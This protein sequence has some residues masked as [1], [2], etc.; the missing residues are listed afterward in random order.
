MTVLQTPKKEDVTVLA[1]FYDL[2]YAREGTP[3]TEKRI[4][5]R[6]HLL[7]VQRGV[8]L[9]LINA[10]DVT[11]QELVKKA[12]GKGKF[13]DT[14]IALRALSQYLR[15]FNWNSLEKTQEE[16]ALLSVRKIAQLLVSYKSNFDLWNQVSPD[17]YDFQRTL[18]VETNTN[19]A[20]VHPKTRRLIF[21]SDLQIWVKD[22]SLE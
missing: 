12:F 1:Q 8:G 3:A 11:I 10:Q 5:K 19:C 14:E 7:G 9:T 20:P 15:Q 13:A 21:D 16:K 18:S 2:E 22:N 4:C 6:S 17:Y